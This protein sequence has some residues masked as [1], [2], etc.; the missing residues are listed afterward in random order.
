MPSDIAPEPDGPRSFDFDAEFS[1]IVSGISG[2][3]EWGTTAAELD[4]AAAQHVADPPSSASAPVRRPPTDP[5]GPPAGSAVPGVRRSSDDVDGLDQLTG[6]DTAED[7]RRR[8]ELRRLER[9]AALEAFQQAQAEIQAERDADDAHFEPPPPPP[10]P[11]PKG[12]TIGALLLILAG[13]GLLVWQELV[14]PAD[15][16]TLVLSLLLLLGGLTLLLFGLRR[17]HGDPGEGWDDGAVL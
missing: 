5:W 15:D 17:R 16:V 9:E 14:A 2:Q 6:P 7:R 8:R 1:A 3:M 13:I 12:R 10:L 4:A 11:R